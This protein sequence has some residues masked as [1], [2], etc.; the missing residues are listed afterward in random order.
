MQIREYEGIDEKQSN[1]SFFTSLVL[2]DECD[3]QNDAVMP[4]KWFYLGR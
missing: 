1:Q 4:A 2:L 3:L